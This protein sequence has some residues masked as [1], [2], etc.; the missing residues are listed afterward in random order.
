M[1]YL[2][3]NRKKTIHGILASVP[4]SGKITHQVRDKTI[5]CFSGFTDA[6]PIKC[7]TEMFAE[8]YLLIKLHVYQTTHPHI[9]SQPT[10]HF[11]RVWHQFIM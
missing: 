1:I 4:A 10:I 5:N 3:R 8:F 9:N 2:Q 7:L 6:F 11:H